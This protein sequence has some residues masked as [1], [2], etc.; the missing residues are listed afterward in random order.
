[1]HEPHACACILPA[2][3]LPE[4]RVYSQSKLHWANSFKLLTSIYVK[5]PCNFFLSNLMQTLFN[6]LL[7]RMFNLPLISQHCISRFN[8]TSD[9]LFSIPTPLK[10]IIIMLNER[11]SDEGRITR[12]SNFHS[13]IVYL[14]S[15]CPQRATFQHF[16]QKTQ[17]E[18][19]IYRKC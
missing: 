8:L 3:S 15:Q 19:S 9:E 5:I 17:L 13:W 18:V 11:E 7:H 16:L 14:Q 4:M 12:Q 6:K 10:K 2:L 1:M